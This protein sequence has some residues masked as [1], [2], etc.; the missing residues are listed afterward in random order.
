MNR[1]ANLLLFL[2]KKCNLS[3]KRSH[4][5]FTSG[6]ETRSR[7]KPPPVSAHGVNLQQ[8]HIQSTFRVSLPAST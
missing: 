7:V 8:L 3:P 4:V 5:I 1:R 2:C 6:A